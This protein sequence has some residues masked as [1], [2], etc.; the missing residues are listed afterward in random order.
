MS[1]GK[2]VV[3]DF[4]SGT[5]PL[6][7]APDLA[8]TPSPDLAATA[9]PDLAVTPTPDLAATATVFCGEFEEENPGTPC[10]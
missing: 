1:F 7:P 10:P 4:I 3:E 6:T 9:T 2:G 5:V 8:V